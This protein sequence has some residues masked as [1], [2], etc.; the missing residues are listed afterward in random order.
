MDC[1]F[2]R[3]IVCCSLRHKHLVLELTECVLGRPSAP[4]ALGLSC[5]AGVRL[6]PHVETPGAWAALGVSHARAPHGETWC[7]G[8]GTRTKGNGFGVRT[9]A[10]WVLREDPIELGPSSKLKVL[11]S[12]VSK[13]NYL[14]Y[15]YYYFY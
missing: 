12:S 7:L 5:V 13:Y 8:H 2:C 6:A 11:G 9:Q 14:Y 3:G 1:T 10:Q 15:K 4:V